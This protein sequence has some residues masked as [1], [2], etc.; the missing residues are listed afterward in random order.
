MCLVEYV[1]FLPLLRLYSVGLDFTSLEVDC[2]R[3]YEQRLLPCWRLYLHAELH[4]AAEL[5][6]GDREHFRPVGGPG[7]AFPAGGRRTTKPSCTSMV[8]SSRWDPLSVSRRG[9]P[10]PFPPAAG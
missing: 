6:P 7:T 5:K 3:L 1:R 10:L 2:T 9:H 4:S 8:T